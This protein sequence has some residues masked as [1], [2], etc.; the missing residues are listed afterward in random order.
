M[1]YLSTGNDQ[2]DLALGSADE[3]GKL[4]DDTGQE[5]EAVVLGQGLE[6]VLDGLVCDA[7]GLGELG[8]DGALV[9]WGQ[10]GGVEDLGELRILLD[11]VTEAGDGLGRGLEGGSLDGGGILYIEKI[12]ND[13]GLTQQS[14]T[15]HTDNLLAVYSWLFFLCSP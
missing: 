8:D 7:R 2:L 13:P 4:G 9:G 5:T 10:A 11:E 3:L 14:V 12:L 15:G 1:P 6:E